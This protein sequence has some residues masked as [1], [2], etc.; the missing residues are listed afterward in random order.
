MSIRNSSFGRRSS[1][2]QCQRYLL[3]ATLRANRGDSRR[4]GM[5]PFMA[6]VSSREEDRD[7]KIF[8]CADILAHA[9]HSV[10]GPRPVPE[11]V[12]KRDLD[13]LLKNIT[14]GGL[15]L[16]FDEC[17]VLKRNQPILQQIRNVFMQSK[18]CMLG[19]AATGITLPRAGE[20]LI[21]RFSGSS[22][23]SQSARSTTDAAV[24]RLASAERLRSTAKDLGIDVKEPDWI[25]KVTGW[26]SAC[27]RRIKPPDRARDL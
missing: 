4:F 24:R 26:G 21:L 2:S 5:T 9:N 22:R 3:M 8:H 7:F 23:R 20:I 15:V 17:D 18:G 6:M 10:E 11:A 25:A 1:W 19:I 16:L 27:R 12:L 13:T 14:R